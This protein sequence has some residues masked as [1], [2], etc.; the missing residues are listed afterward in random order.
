M[1][2]IIEQVGFGV[3]ALI[4]I[5][6]ALAVVTLRNIFHSLLFLAL[7]FLGIAGIYLFLAADFIAVAQ[8]L[9]YVGAI[10]ILMMFA[11]M[12]THRV[13]TTDLRQ[14]LGNWIWAAAVSAWVLIVL[15]RLVVLH[16]W[17]VG[18][19]P[20]KAPTTA[21]IGVE[22]LTRYL[23]PFE[24]AS[25]VLLVAIVGAIVLAKEDKPD[26]PA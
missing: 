19:M 21:T 10:V 11:L 26:D 17:G 13:M 7:A 15:V 9:I 16:P 12:L 1:P 8:V 25:I 18:N 6:S 23:L 20:G 3:M 4:V 22:L 5:G 24:L 2:P 14:T